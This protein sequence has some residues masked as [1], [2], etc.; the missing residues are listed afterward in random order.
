M[1]ESGLRPWPHTVNVVQSTA[2]NMRCTMCYA[3]GPFVSPERP[4]VMTIELF[5]RIV[6]EVGPHI[7]SLSLTNWGEP[8]IDPLLRQRLEVLRRFPHVAIQFQTNG[9]LL[10]RAH[11]QALER[12]PN[13]IR[14]AVSIDAVEPAVYA[15]IRKPFTFG[16]LSN[17]ISERCGSRRPTSTS[18]SKRSI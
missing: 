10:D 4:R 8:F 3:H 9:T 11:L 15:S 18:A 7:R 5:E 12:Q 13:P 2:C 17:R 16:R 14:F 6:S 1:P